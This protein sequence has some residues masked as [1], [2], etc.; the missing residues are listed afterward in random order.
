MQDF[1]V[2]HPASSLQEVDALS[3]CALPASAKIAVLAQSLGE[4]KP[5]KLQGRVVY[6]Y[7]LREEYAKELEQGLRL[8]REL[9]ME[10]PVTFDLAPFGPGAFYI[11]FTFTLEKP[12]LSKDD[13][14]FYPNENPLKK[15]RVLR[16]PMV[17]A[18]TW[19][20]N[21]R[22]AARLLLPNEGQQGLERLFGDSKEQEDKHR[23][24]RLHF[25]P[26]FFDGIGFEIINP[27]DREKRIGKNPIFMECA[28]RGAK[29]RFGLLYVPF[30]PCRMPEEATEAQGEAAERDAAAVDRRR[31]PVLVEW[32]LSWFGFGAKKTSGYGVVAGHFENGSIQRY[33]QPA[34]PLPNRARLISAAQEG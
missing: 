21:M 2:R 5:V 28:P 9:G 14:F 11:G 31:V 18:A 8:V 23:Q 25:Y 22:A 34:I 27:H 29:G 6:E 33:R 1:F 24:G 30:P 3:R 7:V 10:A 32:T 17:S 12:Y 15:D 16:V 19:K 20:G 26:T 13:T 4:D